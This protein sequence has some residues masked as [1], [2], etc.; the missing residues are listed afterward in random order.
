VAEGPRDIL[1]TLL[2]RLRQGPAGAQVSHVEAEWQETTGE[3]GQ[4]H[5]R[6]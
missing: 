2:S 5:I 6:P 1:E 4:F 3:Y